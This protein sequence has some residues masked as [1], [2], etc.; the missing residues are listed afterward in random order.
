MPHS[1][2]KAAK[3]HLTQGITDADM[4]AI[5]KVAERRNEIIIFRATGPW[6]NK[7]IQLGVCP[8]KD[9]G[10]KGKSSTWGP[11][12]GLI[13]LDS[14]LSK[15][16]DDEGVKSGTK[17]NADALA[18]GKV[19][20]V[21]LTLEDKFLTLLS[22]EK[23][24][25]DK[26]FPART[27]I[28]EVRVVPDRPNV[29][30]IFAEKRDGKV[31]GKP[32]DWVFLATRKDAK[33][34]WSIG[35]F[36]K[37]GNDK[38]Y[39]V[40]LDPKPEG[41]A[42]REELEKTAKPVL[43]LARPAKVEYFMTGDYDLFMVCPQWGA[44]GSKD[45]RMHRFMDDPAFMK[46]MV[47]YQAEIDPRMSKT[48]E[49]CYKGIKA[50]WL[51]EKDA[52][53][54]KGFLANKIDL[55]R[56][57]KG[58]E[59]ALKAGE[60]SMKIVCS[61]GCVDP[62]KD[63]DPLEFKPD[64]PHCKGKGGAC[65]APAMVWLICA[66]LCLGTVKDSKGKPKPYTFQPTDEK[67]PKCKGPPSAPAKAMRDYEDGDTVGNVTFR[68]LEVIAELNKE[69]KANDFNKRVHHNAESGR[70]HAPAD[71]TE[72]FPLTVFHPNKP[73][74]HEAGFKFKM[75]IIDDLKDLK[76]YLS[77]IFKAGY[78]VPLNHAWEI[79][80]LREDLEMVQEAVGAT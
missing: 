76:D 40:L 48:V 2:D 17:Y 73:A 60:E 33:D 47:L 51:K 31:T 29:R 75:A 6:P 36:E 45:I 21:P 35:Y 28:D 44:F 71:I 57:A 56:Q 30:Y 19:K 78:F 39:K 72:A 16:M 62:K 68:L 79:K 61:A 8:T 64:D 10:V 55:E 22:K 41:K 43:V 32:K 42:A 65:K 80:N 34:P 59:Q 74:L 15:A 18:K 27:A 13:P 53:T 52:K 25:D 7:Y 9:M 24:Q 46:R 50:Q 5:W 54:Y 3:D 4:E 77:A 69:M 12:A 14:E 20:G 1:F 66:K 37:A 70:F 11:M 63:N 26:N 58:M 67:C 49:D 38:A 23:L